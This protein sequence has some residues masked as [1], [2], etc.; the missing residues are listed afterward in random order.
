[1]NRDDLAEL[2]TAAATPAPWRRE[3]GARVYGDERLII[4]AG[5]RGRANA[6][7][8]A[9]ARNVLPELLRRLDLAEQ[10]LA[11]ISALHFD[12]RTGVDGDPNYW[13]GIC[14]AVDVARPTLAA[15]RRPLDQT[16]TDEDQQ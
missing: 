2:V 9:A 15:I 3:I 4:D 6:E 1:M 14:E 8:I 10:A 16:E 5:P 11:A 7:L 12:S 13:E